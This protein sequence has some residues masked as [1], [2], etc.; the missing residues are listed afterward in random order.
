[1]LKGITI[2]GFDSFE[3]LKEDMIGGYADNPKGTFNLDKQPPQLNN[4]CVPVIGWI[5]NTL[6]KFISEN[7]GLK[8]NFVHI[9][10]DTYFG[11]KASL[12]IFFSLLVDGGIIV[13]DDY[14]WERCKGVTKACNEFIN[15]NLC[16]YSNIGNQFI[17][18]KKL[19]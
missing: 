18:E 5:Q 1:M 14:A 11:T 10:T 9:D 12:S 17:I 16:S 3:G 19:I 7:K 13:I 8:I 2:Y 4:N 15:R 6:P